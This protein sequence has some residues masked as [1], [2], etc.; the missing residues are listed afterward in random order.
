M[1]P[2][3]DD[4]IQAALKQE[5]TGEVTPGPCAGCPFRRDKLNWMDATRI[6]LNVQR[7]R[8]A[9]LQHCHQAP[10]LVCDGALRCAHGGDDLVMDI[11]ELEALEPCDLDQAAHNYRKD[12]ANE[13][14][15]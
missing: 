2:L 14:D 4:F 1:K 8:L 9:L 5:A 3:S 11:D 12:K 15:P 10:H 6:E 13:V 7:I